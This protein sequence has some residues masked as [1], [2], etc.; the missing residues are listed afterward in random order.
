MTPPPP[1]ELFRKFIRFGWGRLPLVFMFPNYLRLK[2]KAGVLSPAHKSREPSRTRIINSTC[3]KTKF[4]SSLIFAIISISEQWT[5]ST[6]NGKKFKG[7]SWEASVNREEIAWVNLHSTLAASLHAVTEATL[8]LSRAT[9]TEF[10]LQDL[11]KMWNNF[12]KGGGWRI[13][14]PYFIFP[15]TLQ[16]P[17]KHPS[18]NLKNHLIFSLKKWTEKN[19]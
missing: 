18:N 13:S 12:G 17:S 10:L 14:Y 11:K 2:T 1:L 8:S 3:C 9:D 4:A 19:K 6:E 15:N 16:T 7:N 5:L